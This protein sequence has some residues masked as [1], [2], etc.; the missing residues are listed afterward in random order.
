MPTRMARARDR[1]TAYLESVRPRQIRAR[2]DGP[3]VFANSVPKSGTNLLTECLSSFPM[4]RPAFV[5]VSMNSNRRPTT[6]ELADRIG[7]LGRG[8]YA[9]GHVFYDEENAAILEAA[10]VRSVLIVRDPRDVVTSH[11][12]YV[13]EKN[14]SHRLT[15]YYRSLPDDDARLLASIR[16]VD[17][18]HT[19]DG[20]PLESVGE[21]LENFL[22]WRQTEYTCLV[23]FE[24]LIGPKGGGDRESQHDTVR[25]IADHLGVEIDDATTRRIAENTFSTSSDTFRKGLIGDWVNHFGR[26]HATAF[27]EVAGDAL[28]ELGYEEDGDWGIEARNSSSDRGDI[29]MSN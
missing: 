2:F 25:T 22:G 19:A 1:L 15:D 3:V 12:K 8:Q 9:S 16:G 23:R 4:L 21:W 11:Y 7:R 13:T 20:D 17:G 28:V 6:D 24:D 18:E 26:E 27:Q 29:G 14:T 10:D 5:H